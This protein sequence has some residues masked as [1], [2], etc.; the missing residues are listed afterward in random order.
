MNF[1]LMR[2]VKK[3]LNQKETVLQLTNGLSMQILKVFRYICIKNQDEQKSFPL[4]SYPKQL[5]NIKLF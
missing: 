2:M 4:M 3:F 5:M 1:S